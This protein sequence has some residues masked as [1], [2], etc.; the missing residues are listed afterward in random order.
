MQNF[1]FDPTKTKIVAY[2]T[3]TEEIEPLLLQE[4]GHEVLD[5]GLYLIPD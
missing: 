4:I 2:A 3:V 1:T 5:F